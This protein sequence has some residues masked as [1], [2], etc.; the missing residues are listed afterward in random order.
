MT[1][2][3]R[4]NNLNRMN[5]SIVVHA[6]KLNRKAVSRKSV[7]STKY[8]NSKRDEMP[9]RQTLAKQ[10]VC[11]DISRLMLKDQPV[12]EMCQHIVN[13]LRQAWSSSDSILPFIEVYNK[14]Y[15][16]GLSAQAVK[17]KV[18]IPVMVNGVTCG[19]V[20]L[21]YDEG[22]PI[23]WED[24][25]DFEL[26]KNVAEDLGLWLKR[27]RLV[28]AERDIFDRIKMIEMG[29]HEHGSVILT[30]QEGRIE[31]ANQNFCSISKYSIEEVQGQNLRIINSGFHDHT[32]IQTFW[33][34]LKNGKIWKGEFKNRAKDGTF[35]W[36]DATVIPILDHIKGIPKQ[37]VAIWTDV[38]AY[39]KLEQK[40]EMQVK[41]LARS[42]DE[43]E[44]FAYVVTHDLQEPLRAINSFVQLLKKYCDDRL[45]T[46]ANELIV[47]AVAG[48]QRMQMLIDD[49]LTYAQVNANQTL[50]DV[51]CEQLL[52]NVLTDLS[53]IIGECH[54]EV[55][56]Q[57]LPVIKG[58]SFQ[59]MQLFTNLINN[60]LKF[61][62]EQPP[63]IYIDVE[64]NMDKWIFSIRDN[65]IGIEEQYLERV[66][67]VFQRLH[68]RKEYVGTGI[69]LA[70]CKKVVEH[71][72]GRI[73]IKSQP[74]VGSTVFFTIPK[75]T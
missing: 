14:C 25:A 33:N 38:T 39:K 30:D 49:L 70:I 48:T 1:V 5:P 72:G 24:E 60:A 34:I 23:Q 26:L 58:I 62:R 12:E 2:R 43:L 31:Y 75:L 13:R 57:K 3:N 41:E 51:D 68:S 69:G 32:F 11:Y 65:G 16:F 35:Y 21:Y 50:V 45:D 61:Q 17:Q 22:S 6:G 63:K 15:R 52:T 73:W 54:A 74:N 42:N 56:H 71:H 18:C 53:V 29:V 8:L 10:A 59:F 47:H 40:M 20:C 66:F 37:Y 4:T 7:G 19:Q 27:Q 28:G 67:R 46:R 44:Q 64:E 36:V 9:A 55:E